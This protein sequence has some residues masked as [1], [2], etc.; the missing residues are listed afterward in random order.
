MSKELERARVE[1]KKKFRAELDEAYAT[2]NE[3]RENNALKSSDLKVKESII[4]NLSEENKKLREL[5][6]LSE[7]EINAILASA[8][9]S[10][11]FNA[12]S[13]LRY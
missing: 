1:M 3:L 4:E 13:G 11:I 8:K 6:K 12:F 2:I 9:V 10:N 5:T 7:S